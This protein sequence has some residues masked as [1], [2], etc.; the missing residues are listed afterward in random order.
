[1]KSWKPILLICIRKLKC[2][3]IQ[4]SEIDLN[5]VNEYSQFPIPKTIIEIILRVTKSP[6]SKTIEDYIVGNRSFGG[7]VKIGNKIK[8]NYPIKTK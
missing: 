2:E 7:G 8:K 1:M 3:N 6:I 4:K 5:S